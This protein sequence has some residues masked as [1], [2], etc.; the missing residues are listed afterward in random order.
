MLVVSGDYDDDE[1]GG[2]KDGVGVLQ[3]IVDIGN[4]I[5]LQVEQILVK[6]ILLMVEEVF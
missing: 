2:K 1:D 3:F 5:E 4:L 6:G